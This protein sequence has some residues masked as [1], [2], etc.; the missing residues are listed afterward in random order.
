MYD[1]L[2]K[3]ILLGPSGVGKYVSISS[4]TSSTLRWHSILTLLPVLD[5]VCSIDL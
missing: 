5:L 1:Y 3:I 2:A 4:D